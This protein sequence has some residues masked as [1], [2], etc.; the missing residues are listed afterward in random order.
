MHSINNTYFNQ[1]LPMLEN[2]PLRQYF[3]RPAVY[4][5]LPSEYKNYTNSEVE[6][7]ESGELPVFPMTA[8]DEITANTPDALF[9]GTAVA[10]IIKSCVPNIKNPWKLIGPDLDVVLLAIRSASNGNE[11]E[12][13]STCPSCKE[14]SSFGINLVGLLATI[15]A[16][17]YETEF[18]I[19]DLSIKFKPL[20][21]KES[22]DVGIKQFE[23][24]KILANI[25]NIADVD[26][27][28]AKQHD[29]LKTITNMTIAVLSQTIEYIKTP[30][31]TVDSKEYIM[32]FLSSCDKQTFDKIKNYQN[33]LKEESELQPLHMKCAACQH[34]YKQKLNINVSDFFG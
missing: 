32:D 25:E 26:E 8:V 30:N 3:R 1:G 27:K 33:R 14:T 7:P 6:I 2:N 28:L 17:N 23:I 21:Y 4:I 11:L 22:S 20:T 16:G 5:K 19:N 31:V 12:I 24:Q 9:N 15:K 18:P 10:D 34:E 29:A 13:E